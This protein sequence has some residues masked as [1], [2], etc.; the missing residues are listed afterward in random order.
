[1]TTV[2]SL[3]PGRAYDILDALE[4][5]A[6]TTSDAV[7]LPNHEGRILTWQTSFAEEPD[8]VDLRL[9]ASIDGVNFVEIDNTTLTTGDLRELYP[10]A[11]T[12]VKVRQASRTGDDAFVTVTLLLQQ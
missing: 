10:A 7:A 5:T 8:A 11:W 4:T 1:M 3:N 12:F 9:L 6:D 2:L